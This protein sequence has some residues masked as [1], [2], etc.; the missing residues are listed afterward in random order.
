MDFVKQAVRTEAKAFP[1]DERKYPSALYDRLLHAGL[2]L[3]T[4]SGEFL[5]ALKKTFFYGRELDTV[6]LIEEIG[7]LLWYVALACDALDISLEEVQH[8]V[9][10]KLRVRYPGQFEDVVDRDVEAERQALE[11]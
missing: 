3:A 8:R 4:E 5:D 2:G 10:E 7:D 9:I 1:L 11:G 6:N